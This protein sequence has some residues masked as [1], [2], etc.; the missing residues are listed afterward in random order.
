MKRTLPLLAIG[1]L[2]LA[3]CNTGPVLVPVKGKIAYDGVPVESGVVQFHA[4]DGESPS[5]KGGAI[6]KGEYAAE[7]PTGELIVKIT[8]SRASGE[9]RKFPENAPDGKWINLSEQYVPA[10][11]NTETTLKVTIQGRKDDL[12]FNLEK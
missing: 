10:K 7:V 2:L 5:A 12:D 1:I 9:K 3:G 4:A 6:I 8:G 11:Y